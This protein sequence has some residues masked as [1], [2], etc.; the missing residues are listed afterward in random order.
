ME[1]SPIYRY[2][3]LELIPLGDE[4]DDLIHNFRI[5]N[6]DNQYLEKSNMDH[7]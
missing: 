7:P 4:S 5:L 3:K 2:V 6:Q 1:A